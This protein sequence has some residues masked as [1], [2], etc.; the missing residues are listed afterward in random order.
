MTDD[1]GVGHRLLG[2]H[3]LDDGIPGVCESSLDGVCPG[4]WTDDAPRCLQCGSA[5]I[6]LADQ[7]EFNAVEQVVLECDRCHLEQRVTRSISVSYCVDLVPKEAK[8][9]SSY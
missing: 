8:H 7:P 2:L 4:E 6:D 5:L 9:G 3:G 1:P